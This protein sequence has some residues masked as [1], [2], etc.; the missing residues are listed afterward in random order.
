MHID[1]SR[2]IV[3]SVGEVRVENEP[4][5]SDWVSQVMN[6][7]SEQSE[8]GVTKLSHESAEEIVR[9]IPLPPGAEMRI[10]FEAA[11]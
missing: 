8:N 11:E 9:S 6:E 2:P 3:F 1:I 5:V 10:R 7:L 4:L